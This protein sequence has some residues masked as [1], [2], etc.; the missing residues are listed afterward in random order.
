[1]FGGENDTQYVGFL[2]KKIGLEII[3]IEWSRV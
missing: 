2:K 3:Y 1:M